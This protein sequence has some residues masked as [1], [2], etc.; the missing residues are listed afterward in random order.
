MPAA[1]ISIHLVLLVTMKL[2]VPLL[3]VI[4]RIMKLPVAHQIALTSTAAEAPVFKLSGIGRLNYGQ[5]EID[6][7]AVVQGVALHGAD[8]V[9]VVTD[10]TRCFLIHDMQPVG[11]AYIGI[12]QIGSAVTFIAQRIVGR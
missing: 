7:V 12:Q 6:Q 11:K 1:T 4:Q 10:G 8:P 3:R 2:Y 5:I 9:R